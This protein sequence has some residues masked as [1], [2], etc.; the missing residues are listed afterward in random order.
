METIGNTAELRKC[1]QSRRGSDR[2]GLT[3]TMGNLHK[4]HLALVEAARRDCEIVVTSIFVNP[5]QFGAGEDFSEYPR[6][7]EADRD[8]LAKAGVDVLFAPFVEEVYPDGQSNQTIVSVPELSR[9]LCGASRPHHFD[10][11]TTVVAKLF[12]MVQPD[13]AYFGE[14]DWQ[15]LTIIRTMVR[16]LNVPIDVIG[17]PIVREEDGVALSSRN[18]YLTEGERSIAAL[19]HQTLQDIRHAI[20]EGERNFASLEQTAKIAL[21]RAGFEPE[22]VAVRDDSTLILPNDAT[23]SLRILAAARLGQA[24]LIDNVS[25]EF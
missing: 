10:G 9:I 13:A 15:Q 2:I 25:V 12:N 24:R 21:K 7:L 14:K 19:L 23:Q 18:D 11:V 1:L 8:K 4:G 5:M 20:S 6:T 3:P 17:V 16:Q 22:Y